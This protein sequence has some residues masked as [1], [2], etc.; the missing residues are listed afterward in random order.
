MTFSPDPR[1]N[2]VAAPVV[3]E[4]EAAGYDPEGYTLYTYAAIQ[5]WAQAAEMAGT[6][7]LEAVVEQLHGNQFET[8]LGTV[9]FDDRGD[10][11]G[12]AYVMYEWADG[13]YNEKGS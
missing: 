12:A 11:E 4:F 13:Q 3:A 9:S 10:V 6:T 5:V 1:K 8:V 7:D 2:E